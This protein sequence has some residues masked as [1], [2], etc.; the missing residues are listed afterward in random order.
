MSIVRGR[1]TDSHSGP[2]VVFLIGMRINHFRKVGK[3]F[4]VFRAMGP[5]LRELSA[6]PDSGFI[7]SEFALVSPRQLLLLQ[8]WRSFEALESYARAR[9]AQHWPAWTAFNRRIGDDG[10]VGI[11]HETYVVAGGAHETV[12]A[13]MPAFGLGRFTGL[14]PATGSR[15][16]ARGRMRGSGGDVEEA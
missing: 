15:N 13:N 1:M 3:W 5:M 2:L 6:Q 14:V 8:Y 9:D 4:P 11:Y 12:Y 10:T 7:G 16:A